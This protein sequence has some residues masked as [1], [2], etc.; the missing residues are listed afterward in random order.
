MNICI[1]EMGRL[2]THVY[3]QMSLRR[4]FIGKPVKQSRM[5]NETRLNRTEPEVSCKDLESRSLEE[6]LCD[7]LGSDKDRKFFCYGLTH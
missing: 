3:A 6:T 5:A 7:H 2:L 1:L 4:P